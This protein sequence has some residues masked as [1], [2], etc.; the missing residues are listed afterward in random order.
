MKLLLFVADRPFSEAVLHYTAMLAGLAESEV[1]LLYVAK[2]VAG[3][4]AGERAIEEAAQ[5]L[6]VAAVERH[7]HVGR[8]MRWL[9]EEVR[10]K[11]HDLVLI[12]ARP[13][14]G[15]LPRTLAS[16]S[17]Q[18]VAWAP[19]SVL[20][21]RYPHPKLERVLICTSGQ[22]AARRLIEEGAR[23]AKLAGATATL[24]YV[25]AMVPSMYTGLDEIEESLGELLDT[26][27]PVAR[28]LR[29]GAAILDEHGVAADL[30]LRHGTVVDAILNEAEAGEYDLIVMG[31]SKAK[32]SLRG[33]V[34]GDV[35]RQVVERAEVPVLV[36]R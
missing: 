22:D 4:D 32:R 20:V 10:N 30:E 2:R 26:D 31:A 13:G 18:A 11:Q 5:Q 17:Q 6:S 1:D 21:V 36:V 14:L 3:Q 8:P 25:S 24:L 28:H 16:L 15:F 34:M 35:T 23:L 12:G 7:L 19:A 33:W 9:A 27:T 29:Q